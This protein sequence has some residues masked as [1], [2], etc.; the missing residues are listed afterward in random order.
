[1]ILYMDS[2]LRTAVVC[3][4]QPRWVRTT[5]GYSTA[6]VS[7]TGILYEY[8]YSGTRHVNSL[9]SRVLYILYL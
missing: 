1:M 2:V 5:R 4:L 6:V 9:L 3:V 7:G 8:T